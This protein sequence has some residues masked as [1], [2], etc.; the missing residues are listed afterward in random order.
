MFPGHILEP[1]LKMQCCNPKFSDNSLSSEM[2]LTC[3]SSSS[4][5]SSSS[6]PCL[7]VTFVSFVVFFCAGTFSM[8][9]GL[10]P[11]FGLAVLLACLVCWGSCCWVARSW[12]NYWDFWASCWV[13]WVLSCK[14]HF[15]KLNDILS[16]CF[17]SL[18]E[19]KQGWFLL[20]F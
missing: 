14:F 15:T 8:C 17:L 5:S 3:S 20:N 13:G 4:S 19:L 7:F 6:T 9:L 12:C 10:Y 1:A 16:I 11:C 2:F 18:L